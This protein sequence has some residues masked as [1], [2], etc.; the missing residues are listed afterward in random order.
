MNFIVVKSSLIPLGLVA[1][2]SC[3]SQGSVKSNDELYKEAVEDCIFFEEKD[4]LPLVN[5]TKEDNRVI[6]N[7]SNKVLMTFAHKYP[8]S[9]PSQSDIT[10]QWGNVWTVSAGEFYEFIKLNAKTTTDWTLRINQVLG[11]PED[12]GITSV[13][14]IWVDPSI[15]YRPAYEPN[16]T[17]S[18]STTL[19][20]T[21]NEEFDI[22]FKDFFDDNIIWSYFESSYPW[23]R[24]GYTY[25]WYPNNTKYG[26]SEFLI[27]SGESAF[28]EYTYSI[29]EF[30]NFV[31]S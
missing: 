17:K 23:T 13:T 1:L 27:F 15:L 6:W 14:G 22:K 2:I 26:L 12:K 28:I 18:M 8:S 11:M 21:G 24:L 29:D 9:Y 30:I 3:S 20:K 10:F 4:V 5:I 7:D 25:D 31:I 19:Q 16:P